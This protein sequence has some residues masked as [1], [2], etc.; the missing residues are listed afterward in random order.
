[1]EVKLIIVFWELQICLNWYFSFIIFYILA[2]AA[3]KFQILIFD[4]FISM[5][6]H[7]TKMFIIIIE[8]SWNIEVARSA[9]WIFFEGSTFT[10]GGLLMVNRVGGG[11]F[12]GATGK[13]KIV[14]RKFSWFFKCPKNFQT[15]FVFFEKIFPLY[16]W[17]LRSEHL[18]GARI[19]QASAFFKE[20]CEQSWE[21]SN[22]LNNF[23]NL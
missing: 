15:F 12:A 9:R 7:E 21:A 16:I 14:K 5:V 2:K 4:L 11:G 23:H 13:I 18:W 1:M 22:V 3:S 20:E 17:K 10:R 6:G 19:P 8:K